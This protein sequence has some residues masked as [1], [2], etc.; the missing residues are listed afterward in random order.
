MSKAVAFRYLGAAFLLGIIYSS[1]FVLNFNQLFI[2]FLSC[3]LILLI[4]VLILFWRGKYVAVCCDNKICQKNLF[5]KIFCFLRWNN[6]SFQCNL[7]KHLSVILIIFLISIFF[8]LGNWRFIS[9]EQKIFRDWSEK[10][11]QKIEII[12]KIIREPILRQETQRVVVETEKGLISVILPRAIIYQY[13]DLLSLSGEIKIPENNPPFF[14]KNY[15]AK[16]NIFAEMMFPEKRLIYQSLEPSIF[17]YAQRVKSFFVSVTQ[18]N[19]SEPYASLLT[20]LILG[21]YSDLS[22]QLKEDY[23]RAG[24]TH[25]LVVSGYHL[26][27]I[28]DNLIKLLQSFGLAPLFV[29]WISFVSIVFY[30]AIAG[31]SPSVIR[32]AIMAILVLIARSNSRFYNVYNALLLAA[33]LM[34]WHNPKILLFDFG[35]Q[36]SFLATMGLIYL[37][38]Y[39]VKIWQLEKKSFLNWKQCLAGTFSALVFVFPWIFYKTGEISLIAPLSNFLVLP[40]IPL[41]MILGFIFICFA[42][43][44]PFLSLLLSPL[45]YF[46]L[47]YQLKI[48]EILATWQWSVIFL[49]PVLNWL[50]FPYYLSLFYFIYLQNKK[51]TF[52]R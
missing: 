47:N 18:K 34:I 17:G 24:L 6:L 44:L 7:K 35:F 20:G 37:Y 52:K 21:D 11:G 50:I 8:I 5:E 10:E 4:I 19:I 33:I 26:S 15:L 41:T 3:C 14:W 31:F 43:F 12:G 45:I 9:Y 2:L 27:L 22:S 48:V 39:F 1:F 29:F 49:S 38:P 23:R 46:L 16:E 13:G 28:A 32:A 51:L 40:L 30:S 25:V 36:L 42:A